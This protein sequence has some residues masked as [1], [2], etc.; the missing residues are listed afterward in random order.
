MSPTF[1]NFHGKEEDRTLWS[2]FWVLPSSCRKPEA[3]TLKL[4]LQYLISCFRKLAGWSLSVTAALVYYLKVKLNLPLIGLHSKS[5]KY[6][7]RVKVSEWIKHTSLLRPCINFC[8]KKFYITDNWRQH[9][10]GHKSF[11]QGI[12]NVWK[13]GETKLDKK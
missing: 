6:W 4:L 3:C 12:N 1:V 9:W 11:G 7:T 8:R 2:F 10:T 13:V 5:N